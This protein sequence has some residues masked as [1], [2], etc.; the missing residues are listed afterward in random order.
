MQ[1]LFVE[2][3]EVAVKCFVNFA[4]EQSRIKWQIRRVSDAYECIDYLSGFQDFANRARFP[5]PQIV[6]LSLSAGITR[7]LDLLAW[8]RGEGQFRD[9]PVVVANAPTGSTEDISA[10]ELAPRGCFVQTAGYHQVLSLC[11]A[12][13]LNA[14][15]SASRAT[16]IHEPSLHAFLGKRSQIRLSAP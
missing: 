14:Y 11:E 15:P 16:L 5:L 4:Y 9:L 8:L 13:V 12:V 3:S 10:C 6:V 7:A 1:L 2:A